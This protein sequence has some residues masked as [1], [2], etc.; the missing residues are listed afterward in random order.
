MCIVRFG[1]CC[2]TVLDLE[3]GQRYDVVI[4]AATQSGFPAIHES[5]WLW[6]SHLVAGSETTPKCNAVTSWHSFA[7]CVTMLVF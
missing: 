1:T 2:D 4:L 3:S 6:V 7:D 5:D